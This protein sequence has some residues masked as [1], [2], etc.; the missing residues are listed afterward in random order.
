MREERSCSVCGKMT[1]KLL[2]KDKTLNIA[3][4]STQCEHQFF[5]TLSRADEDKVLRQ[6]DHRIGE[7]KS[8]NRMCWIIAGLGAL[9]AVIGFFI[10]NVNVF[11]AGV[12]T[13]TI[14]TFLTRHFEEKITKLTEKRK[15]IA[16]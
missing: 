5:D 11:L 12:L 1:S 13:T 10:I 4:C 6:L 3:M 15:R 7:A 8:H 9:V 2:F 14:V 16:I